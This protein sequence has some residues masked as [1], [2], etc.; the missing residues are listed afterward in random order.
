[1][2]GSPNKMSVHQ[3]LCTQGLVSRTEST[4]RQGV[5]DTAVD[6]VLTEQEF[7]EHHDLH[8]DDLL[9]DVYFMFTRDSQWEALERARCHEHVRLLRWRMYRVD[10]VEHKSIN[11]PEEDRMYKRTCVRFGIN[12]N[13][14]VR[15]CGVSSQSWGTAWH[16]FHRVIGYRATRKTPKMWGN[17]F[18]CSAP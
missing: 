3:N 5:I 13:P 18:V 1:M 14:F 10:L 17:E 16:D 7:Q 15:I 11:L 8:Q 9:A 12:D 4:H 2:N 6:A